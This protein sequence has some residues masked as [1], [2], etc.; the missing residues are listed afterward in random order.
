MKYQVLARK[1][2]PQNLDQIAGQKNI[3][4]AIKNSFILNRIH[5]AWL[6]YGMRGTGKT[7][8]ARI[9][10]KILNC[11]NKNNEIACRICTNC[12]NIEKGTFLDLIEV[13]AASR[14]KVEDMKDLLKNIQYL[15]IEGQLKIYLIDEVHMLSRHSFNALLNYIE[16]PPIHVK[17]ILA[18]TNI[19]K[20]PK[21]IISRC[22]QLN[23]KPIKELEIID[24]IKYILK[25]EKINFEEHAIKYIA[26]VSEGSLRDALSLTEHAILI[27]KGMISVQLILVITGSLHDHQSIKIITAL[28]NNHTVSITYI[29]KKINQLNIEW[30]QILL[31]ILRILH[32]IA[33]IQSF[34][35]TWDNYEFS[36]TN[37]NQLIYLAKSISPLLIHKSYQELLLGRKELPFAPNSKIGVEMSLLRLINIAKKYNK[38]KIKQNIEIKN[39]NIK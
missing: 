1:W 5:H 3:I 9:L 36:K 12:K 18:T 29:F 15:P 10:A 28:L 25:K 38:T 22:L 32:Q 37:H 13:D 34:Q 11:K 21:T 8:I 33:M 39:N 14:T 2:R 4:Q 30:D 17:F 26:R 20:V 24:K 7:S 27:G 16:E 6:L 35:S 31:N 19:E 23:L